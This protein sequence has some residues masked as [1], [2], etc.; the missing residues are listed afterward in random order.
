MMDLEYFQET[1][2]L[3][4]LP[5]QRPINLSPRRK[6]SSKHPIYISPMKANIISQS[7]QPMRY[8]FNRSPSKDLQAINAFICEERSRKRLLS[9]EIGPRDPS[10]MMAPPP[11]KFPL[12]VETM[13]ARKISFQWPH[14]S[15]QFF[16]LTSSPLL[17]LLLFKRMAIL[18]ADLFSVFASSSP[19]YPINYQLIIADL[20]FLC[21]FF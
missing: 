21:W 14:S 15:S 9:Y 1:L 4:P 12:T 5:L 3:S 19:L 16:S 20:Y 11:P 18:L 7:P 10:D 2:P 13:V 8:S 6:L 17:S